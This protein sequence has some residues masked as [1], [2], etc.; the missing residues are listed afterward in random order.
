MHHSGRSWWQAWGS[1]SICQG[2]P[3]PGLQCVAGVVTASL[4]S[5]GSPGFRGPV[6]CQPNL[7]WA[8]IATRESINLTRSQPVPSLHQVFAWKMVTPHFWA[9]ILGTHTAWS[10]AS[11]PGL[12]L[13]ILSMPSW[14]SWP[15]FSPRPNFAAVAPMNIIS[16]RCG[17]VILNGGQGGA[18]R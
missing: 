8:L 3:Q 13:H 18:G 7:C 4:L 5:T 9:G 1:A 11:Y 12:S 15:W 10:L 14:L 6:G 2:V 17:F 16:M